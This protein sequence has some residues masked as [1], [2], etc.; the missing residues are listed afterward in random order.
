MDLQICQIPFLDLCVTTL[1]SWVN[2]LNIFYLLSNVCIYA[3][4]TTT[5]K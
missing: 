4:V 3:I 2:N 5:M 1:K